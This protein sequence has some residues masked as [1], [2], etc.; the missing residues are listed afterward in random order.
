VSQALHMPKRRVLACALAALLAGSCAHTGSP[1][2]VAAQPLECEVITQL[3]SIK[4]PYGEGIIAETARPP[5]TVD[6]ADYKS[7]VPDA[8][9]KQRPASLSSCPGLRRRLASV[10][11]SYSRVALN[12]DAT[13]AVVDVECGVWMLRRDRRGAPWTIDASYV[14]PHGCSDYLDGPWPRPR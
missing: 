11:V 1:R 7:T 10:G 8:L 3:S 13:R 4:G 5:P 2:L 12:H 6:E 9:A 14:N